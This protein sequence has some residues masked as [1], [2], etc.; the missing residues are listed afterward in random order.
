MKNPKWL[1]A[2]QLAIYK[3]GQGFHLRTTMNKINSS[4]IQCG[5]DLVSG[6]LDCKKNNFPV[7]NVKHCVF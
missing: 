6:P 1:E 5:A 3:C 2:N 4:S 7:E